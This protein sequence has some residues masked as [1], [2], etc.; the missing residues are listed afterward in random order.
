MTHTVKLPNGE[1]VSVPSHINKEWFVD[2]K[3]GYVGPKLLAPYANQ[4]RTYIDEDKLKELEAS[5]K[6]QGVRESI[7]VTPMSLAPWAA[8]AF[9]DEQLPFLIV[10][11]HRRHRGALGADILAVPIE[12][13]VYADEEAFNRDAEVLNDHRVN[14]SEIEEG[15]QFR[16]KIEA[17]RKITHLV[18]ET[19]HAFQWIQGRIYL[20]YLCPH[21]QKFISPEL[22]PRDRMAIGY[23]SA[24][25][26]VN[27]EN[28]TELVERLQSLKADANGIEVLTEEEKKF[29]LQWAYYTYCQKQGWKGVASANFVR[30]GELPKVGKVKSG[31]RH[32]TASIGQYKMPSALRF[33]LIDWF[34]M[35]HKTGLLDMTQSE[36][37]RALVN[38]VKQDLEGLRAL[39]KMVDETLATVAAKKPTFSEEALGTQTRP[40]QK[41]LFPE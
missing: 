9:G 37:E 12:V 40:E 32:S 25:G 23:A 41:V 36:V 2:K 38:V 13:R 20:T 16:R 7:V 4:P 14:L 29:R 30:T 34:M 1:T 18:E 33:R 6:S 3:T 27:F 26:A 19:G 22:K 5:I 35:L 28:D 31:G 10:S 8:V 39:L 11:G 15:W 24:L 21:L 17:G